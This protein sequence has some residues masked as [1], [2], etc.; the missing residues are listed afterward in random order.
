[1]PS[2]TAH[3]FETTVFDPTTRAETGLLSIPAGVLREVGP[4][5]GEVDSRE[6]F[7]AEYLGLQVGV[8][9]PTPNIAEV[10][11]SLAGRVVPF[12][13]FAFERWRAQRLGR[14]DDPRARFAVELTHTEFVT[15]EESPLNGATLAQ[16]ASRGTPWRCPGGPPGIRG[17]ASGS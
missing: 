17:W 5:L 12:D 15:I 1:M 3:F 9:V 10:F 4:P 6:G 16:L 7:I 14:P 2:G 8:R 11:A 13:D